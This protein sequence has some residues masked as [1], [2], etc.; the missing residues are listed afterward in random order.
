MIGQMVKIVKP[1]TQG[2]IKNQNHKASLRAILPSGTR[3]N[4]RRLLATR[5]C[6]TV[7]AAIELLLEWVSVLRPAPPLG[8]SLYEN[9]CRVFQRRHVRRF[10]SHAM[11][12]A[13]LSSSPSVKG[14]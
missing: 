8:R 3:L 14:R 12:Y 1:I 4:L 9:A 11:L 10:R 7:P 5:A 13:S 6:D 2:E